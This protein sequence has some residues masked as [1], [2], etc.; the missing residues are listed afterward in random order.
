MAPKKK[1]INRV[2]ANNNFVIELV[3]IDV[4]SEV[5]DILDRMKLNWVYQVCKRRD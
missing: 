3:N 4:P 5:S 2:D 1:L